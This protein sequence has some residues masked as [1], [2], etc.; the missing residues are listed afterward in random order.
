[1]TTS[2]DFVAG[3]PAYL[4]DYAMRKLLLATAATMGALLATTGGAKAQPMKPV[5]PGTIAVHINGYIQFEIADYGSSYNTVTVPTGTALTAGTYKL[6]PI[7]TDGDVRLYAGFDAQTLS[8]ID[9]GAQVELR[10]VT[11]D[12]GVGA[13]KVTGTGSTAG[14]D[15]LYVKRAYGYLGTPETGFG[16]AGQTDGAFELLQTGVIEAFGDGAQF[17]TDGGEESILPTDATPA[18]F[19]YADTSSLYATDKI[20]YI[21]PS[22][23]GLNAA[24]SYE[25]N[26]NAI[27]EGFGNNGFA[28]DTSAA[29]ASSP[30]PGDIGKRRRNTVDG[31][32]QYVLKS[33]DVV[34][35]ASAGIL[36]GAPIAF[37][38][39][40]TA[41]GTS[42]HFGFDDLEVYQVGGQ[43]TFAGLTLG[44]NL[45]GGQVE[46]GYAFK[47][48][49]AR[50]S[51]TYIV[52]ADYVIG[53]YVLGAS[54]WNGQSAGGFIPGAAAPMAHT[55]SEYGVAAGGN[56]VIGPDLSLFAQYI[57][58]HKHQPGNTFGVTGSTNHLGNAQVQALATGFTLKW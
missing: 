2:N 28:T 53:P 24:V 58:G 4:E 11:S 45:K 1:L 19:I 25:P 47:P 35:K 57:Y 33:D 14:S 9:Y 16:R 32:V 34:Y 13:N 49:G 43:M 40:P 29:L 48:K 8:G 41:L 36:Y 6:N 44:A 38:G 27:K 3:E 51:L 50:N 7:A 21:S 12:A 30:T 22:F 46:D 56:Y 52:G 31:M 23:F 17:N 55:L 42:T 20:V 37:S 15:G 39:A 5:A 26:S 18:N 54:Y 10:T